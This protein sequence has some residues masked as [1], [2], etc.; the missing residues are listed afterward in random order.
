MRDAEFRYIE[1]HE[2]WLRVAEKSD[3]GVF[4][5]HGFMAY[6]P[7][8]PPSSSR[9]YITDQRVIEKVVEKLRNQFGWGELAGVPGPMTTSL[10]HLEAREGEGIRYLGYENQPI[11]GGWW[12]VLPVDYHENFHDPERCEF[13][14]RVCGRDVAFYAREYAERRA[15][16][17]SLEEFDY[18]VEYASVGGA[19]HVFNDHPEAES[20]TRDLLEREGAGG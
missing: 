16:K 17:T 14:V 4:S 12:V 5:M 3:G 9:R 20:V 1:D 13:Q 15:G 19:V 6:N 2:E 10:A 7:S 18:T 8:A 11:E